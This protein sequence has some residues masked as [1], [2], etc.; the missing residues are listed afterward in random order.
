M[1]LSNESLTDSAFKV[2]T[3]APKKYCVRPNT[4]YVKAGQTIEVQGTPGSARNWKRPWV[5]PPGPSQQPLL[6]CCVVPACS[7]DA[8]AEGVAGRLRYV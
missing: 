8:S 2:K 6:S 3:T 4:G 5:A 7:H 1:C